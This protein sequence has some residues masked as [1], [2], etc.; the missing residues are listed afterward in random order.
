MKDIVFIKTNK[1]WDE[2]PSPLVTITTSNYNRRDVLLRCMKSVDAQTFRDIEYIV[3]DNGSTV[4]FDDIMEQFMEEATIPVMFIKRSCGTGRHNGRNSATEQARGEYISMI[5]SDDEYLP[6]A[7]ETLVKVWK[8]I[9]E[10]ERALYREVVGQSQDEYGKRVGAPFPEGINDCSIKEAFKIVQ[11]PEL[12]FEHANMSRTM[13][14]KENPFINPE[15]VTDSPE[16]V[17]WWRLAKHYKTYFINDILKIYYTESSDS[18][19]TANKRGITK[20]ACIS[21]LWRDQYYLNHWNDYL[22]SFKDRAMKVIYYNVWKNILSNHKLYPPF[23]WAK[24][25]LKGFTNNALNIVLWL[26]CKLVTKWYL[27]THEDMIR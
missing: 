11:R 19:S 7:I 16:S 9:P 10:N 4:S 22:F 12:R 14:L 13:L 2:H 15:G 26:P 21:A 17:I 18:I 8:R 5:D 23:D 25:G 20:N 24:D 27:R 6:T 3:V 1:L